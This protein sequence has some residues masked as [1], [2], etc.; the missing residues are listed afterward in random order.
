MGMKPSTKSNHIL[1]EN[2]LI[3]SF[4][5]E[6]P[7]SKLTNPQSSTYHH[8]QIHTKL[9]QTVLS[10]PH[11][12]STTFSSQP[13]PS[14]LETESFVLLSGILTPHFHLRSSSERVHRERNEFISEKKSKKYCEVS[15]Q[16]I[17]TV[18][19]HDVTKNLMNQKP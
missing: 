2:K 7:M 4:D 5:E 10:Y 17:L 6:S 14:S 13:S 8:H 12:S 18:S 3:L 11:F 1:L 16:Q 15:H 9:L 19:N